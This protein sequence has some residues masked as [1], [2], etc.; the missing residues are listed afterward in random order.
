M[1]NN[2]S[3]NMVS[4]ARR[5]VTENTRSEGF[6]HDTFKSPVDV[7]QY[8]KLIFQKRQFEVELSNLNQT[9]SRAKA[10]AYHT[11]N[12]MPPAAWKRT[13]DRMAQLRKEILAI[14]K[15]LLP[16]REER[17]RIAADINRS[18]DVLFRT[19]AK[20]ILAEPVYERIF[21]AAVHRAKIE[22]EQG[23]A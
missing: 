12:Y 5:S 22:S 15:Q 8:D 10:Q 3:N 14:E 18:F 20:E 6:S 13:Q 1:A 21:T 7:G 9:L 4:R 19:V 17:K 2:E 11:K 16:I 23:D